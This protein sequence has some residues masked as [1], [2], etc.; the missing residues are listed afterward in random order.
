MADAESILK[1]LP[2]P[3]AVKADAWDAFE[4]SSSEEDLTRRLQALP[5]PEEA[6]AALWDLKFSGAAVEAQPKAQASQPA[7]AVSRL[8][9]GVGE[10][11]NPIPLLR[12]MSKDSVLPL[13]VPPPLAPAAAAYASRDVLTGMGERTK[14]KA[15]ESV[16]ALKA[17]KPGEALF[18]AEEAIPIVG[19]VL[20][21]FYDKLRTGDIAGA[22]GNVMGLA[23]PYGAGKLTGALKVPIR[24]G[25]SRMEQDALRGVQARGVPVSTSAASGS[26]VMTGAAE[27]AENVPIAGSPVTKAKTAATEALAR[28]GKQLAEAIAPGRGTTKETAGVALQESFGKRI[29]AL[30]AQADVSYNELRRIAAN[31]KKDI[32]TGTKTVITGE[33]DIPESLVKT[34]EPVIETIQMPVDQR[35]AKAALR[36]LAE[37]LERTIPEA[38]RQMSPGYSAL[39]DFLNTPDFVDAITADKNLGA[40]KALARPSPWEIPE[41]RNASQGIA[42]STV[43]QLHRAVDEAVA[44]AGPDAVQALNRGRAATK[45]KYEAWKTAS[46]WINAEPVRLVEALVSQHD[47]S[48]NFLRSVKKLA[49]AEMPGVARSVVEGIL[50]GTA[51]TGGYTKAKTALNRW[52]AIGDKTKALLFDPTKV[53]E[54]DDFFLG[55][56]VLSRVRNPSGTGQISATGAAGAAL[57]ADPIKAM[58]GLLGVRGL[59]TALASPA[60]GAMILRGGSIPVGAPIAAGTKAAVASNLAVPVPPPPR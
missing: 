50:E 47:R 52:N 18:H 38:K 58:M 3:D 12:S 6:K 10:M 49:P 28:T 46:K 29:H 48:V 60:G 56:D 57:V 33:P 30:D 59:A 39:K 13:L 19:N 21:G 35:A 27:L 40:I 20:T 4:T 25:L 55:A 9:S 24:S 41:M 31:S 14:Q 37:R 26:K 17:G 8:L 15:G 11:L 16:E 53:K 34:T 32:Q 7:G 42:A 44:Q 22:I 5:M 1:P 43:K 36:Q 45:L 23:A 51:E 54:L 2:I